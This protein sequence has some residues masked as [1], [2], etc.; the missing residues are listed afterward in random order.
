MDATLFTPIGG[1]YIGTRWDCQ[2]YVFGVLDMQGMGNA[3]L[4]SP[5]FDEICHCIFHDFFR[6]AGVT[7]S[8][9]EIS[10]LF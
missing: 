2:V 3:F 6:E 4:K 8:G 5:L 1:D 10:G 7:N 9:L